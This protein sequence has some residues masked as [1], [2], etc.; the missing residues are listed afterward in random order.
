M[1]CVFGQVMNDIIN[2]KYNYIPKTE[3]VYVVKDNAGEIFYI[4]KGVNLKRR[5]KQFV[6]QG[7]GKGD[8][9]R[10]GKNLFT[11]TGWEDFYIEFTECENARDKEK[12]MIQNYKDKHNGDRPFANKRD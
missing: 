7:Y 3:G 2:K 5:I 9:H 6:Y 4:G 8:N 11:L 1:K 12:T 10:G